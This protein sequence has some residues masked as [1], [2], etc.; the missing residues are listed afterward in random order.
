M[1]LDVHAKDVAC[2]S[3][4]LVGCVCQLNAAS[5][6]AA[7]SLD[8]RLDDDHAANALGC[9]TSLLRR[10]TDLTVSYR[11]TVIGEELPCLIFVQV[12]ARSPRMGQ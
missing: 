8:L 5:L 11:N 7:T 9:G 6:A 3:L 4:C 10:A 12:H 1:T 2:A